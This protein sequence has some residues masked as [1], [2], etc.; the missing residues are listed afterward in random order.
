ERLQKGSKKEQLDDINSKMDALRAPVVRSDEK[1]RTIKADLDSRRS[2]Y[3]IEVE[4]HGP[5]SSKAQQY[6]KEIRDLEERYAKAQDE[7][8]KNKQKMQ[9]LLH[10]KDNVEKDWSLAKAKVKKLRED[11]DIQLKNAQQK[12]WR[13]NDWFRSL[14]VVDAFNSPLRI[15]QYT[16]ADL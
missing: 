3:D 13:T 8:D 7:F 16:L 15:Q 2:F 4:K 5:D 14:P 6:L 9:E 12:R 10:E 11:F 1:A